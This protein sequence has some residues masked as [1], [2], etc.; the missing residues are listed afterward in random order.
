MGSPTE[1]KMLWIF[2]SGYGECGKGTAANYLVANF[3]MDKLSF[4]DGV[5][6]EA[7]KKNE[8][9]DDLGETYTTIIAN[10]GY[11]AAK[12]HQCI[13]D[14]LVR[15]GH[16]AREERGKRVWIIDLNKKAANRPNGGLM[17]GLTVDDCRYANE[18][19]Y[20]RGRGN[21]ISIRIKREGCKA[22]HATEKN[23]LKEMTP[24]FTLR[25]DG[26][27]EELY[28][29]INRVISIWC[30]HHPSK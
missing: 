27:R 21:C 20:G 3:N 30:L 14:Y 28:C 18:E 16:G 6:D 23:S 25:N 11:E 7:I 22:K 8:F 5:R 17:L 4:A 10:M 9:L 24:D 26:T 2:F 29:E 12:K 1:L 19:E 15:I 13:R